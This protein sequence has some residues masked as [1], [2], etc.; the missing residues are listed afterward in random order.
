MVGLPGFS[1]EAFLKTYND[2]DFNIVWHNKALWAVQDMVR[3]T[4]C[5]A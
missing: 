5:V 3:G 2:F 1:R 4:R